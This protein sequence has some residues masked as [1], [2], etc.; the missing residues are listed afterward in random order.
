[1]DCM[2]IS[3]VCDLT[4]TGADAFIASV[5]GRRR[6]KLDVKVPDGAES[7]FLGMGIANVAGDIACIKPGPGNYEG[8]IRDIS[9]LP[10]SGN[11]MGDP[12]NAEE[13]FESRSEL[14]ALDWVDRSVSG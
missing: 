9:I 8:D 1:M 7:I 2:A 12:L 6:N 10:G 14:G 5:S 3:H 13:Q 4:I 11:Q